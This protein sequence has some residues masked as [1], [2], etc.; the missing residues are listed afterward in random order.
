MPSLEQ[1]LNENTQVTPTAPEEADSFR[2]VKN[3]TTKAL[4]AAGVS[5]VNTF[6]TPPR[7]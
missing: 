6:D 4:E 2:R 1:N 7:S 5:S 3:R